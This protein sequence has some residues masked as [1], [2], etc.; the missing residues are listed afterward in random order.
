[1]AF[2]LP[3]HVPLLRDRS[4]KANSRVSLPSRQ[5]HPAFH[6]SSRR[7]VSVGDIS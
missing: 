6:W 7:H 2:E 4:A 3:V 1:M 5:M